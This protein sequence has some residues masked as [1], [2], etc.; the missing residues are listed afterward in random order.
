[1]KL[2]YVLFGKEENKNYVKKFVGNYCSFGFKED[3]KVFISE[4]V[5]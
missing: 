5:E 3:V 2:I 4:E 1:M